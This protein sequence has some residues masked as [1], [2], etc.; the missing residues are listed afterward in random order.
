M[1]YPKP[2]HLSSPDFNEHI[3]DHFAWMRREAAV[4]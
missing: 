2:M 3:H 1:A 4:Y